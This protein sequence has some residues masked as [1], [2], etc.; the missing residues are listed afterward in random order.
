M[1]QKSIQFEI[2][3]ISNTFSIWEF[4]GKKM[5]KRLSQK[6][7]TSGDAGKT[8]N[9]LALFRGE[10][11]MYHGTLT[12]VDCDAS[13]NEVAQNTQKTHFHSGN[14]LGKEVKTTKSEGTNH[15]RPWE[16]LQYFSTFLG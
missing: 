8:C 12:F 3:V 1:K 15:W 13:K 2:T 4:F 11:T 16:N 5:Q 7:P 14:F 6:E 10:S 9:I